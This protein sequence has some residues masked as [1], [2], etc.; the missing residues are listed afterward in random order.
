MPLNMRKKVF[1]TAA[2]TGLGGTQD[3]SFHIHISSTDT[4][5]AG[6][7][8]DCLKPIVWLGVKLGCVIF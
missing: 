1:I 3:K 6:L 2:L 5:C 8:W 4:V 7:R